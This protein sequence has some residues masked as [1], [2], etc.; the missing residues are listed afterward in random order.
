MS[1]LIVIGYDNKFRAEEVRLSL[2][3]MEQDYLN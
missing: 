3:K 2:L 1:E